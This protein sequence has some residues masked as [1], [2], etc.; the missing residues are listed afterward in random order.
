MTHGDDLGARE[1]AKLVDSEG[2][3]YPHPAQY[4]FYHR[5]IC[6]GSQGVTGETADSEY[7]ERSHMRLVFETVGRPLS[8]FKSTKELVRGFRDAIYGTSDYLRVLTGVKLTCIVLF[9]S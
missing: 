7:N 9:R 8:Q 6:R 4:E 1:A 3:S 2:G 5:T